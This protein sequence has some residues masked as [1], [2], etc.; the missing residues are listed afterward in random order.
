MAD[1]L[2]VYTLTIDHKHGTATRVF[3]SEQ[4]SLDALAVWVR[5]WWPTEVARWS[6][7]SDCI[8][9][10]EFDALPDGKAIAEYFERMCGHESYSLDSATLED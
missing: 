4:G 10:K 7:K 5:M 3:R 2:T 6:E 1:K 8:T 9:Q